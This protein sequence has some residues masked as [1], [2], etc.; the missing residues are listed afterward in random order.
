[1]KP[2]HH[3]RQ[4]FRNNY[5]H[6]RRGARDTLRFLWEFKRQRWSRPDFPKAT[7][8][9]AWLR[10]NRSETSLTWVGHDT[11]LLQVGGLNIL[12]DPH[13]TN[14]TSPSRWLGPRRLA[15]L[16]LALEQLPAV[17]LVLVSHNHYDHLDR[18]SVQWLARRHPQAQFVVPL[19]VRKWMLRHG[20]RKTAELDWWQ[21]HEACGARIT[22]VP[23]QHFSGRTA[24]DGNRSLWCGFM[25]EIAGRKIYFAGDSGYSRDFADIGRR[26]APMDL[27]L[28]PIGAYEPRWFMHPMHVNPEE[29]VKIHHDVGSRL[30][31]AMHWGT[32]RLTQEPLDEP[33]R[34]LAAALAAAGVHHDQFWVMQHGETRILRWP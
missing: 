7:N 24:T 19:G 21:D 3:T 18:R 34:A 13:F 33:P 8:D 23:A 30:S 22:A 1:M 15:P 27:S 32:F 4:G 10:A 26:F 2:K 16:G 25:L 17:D 12:T 11:F 14:R 28:I 5:L 9:P 29:A 20:I 6:E 31:V